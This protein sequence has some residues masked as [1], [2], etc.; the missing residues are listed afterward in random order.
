[1]LL[2]FSEFRV[3]QIIILLIL[4]PF[5][6]IIQSLLKVFIHLSDFQ[7]FSYKTKVHTTY[8]STFWPNISIA[9]QYGNDP[10]FKTIIYKYLKLIN[11][12]CIVTLP[13]NILLT[14]N[15]NQIF[16]TSCIIY[17]FCPNYLLGLSNSP[18][19]SRFGPIEV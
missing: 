9:I 10:A 2:K 16:I 14:I 11:K 18:K 13:T 7:F 17:V 3:F 1:M 8:I 12:D 6:V 15:L 5:H 4:G 19:M